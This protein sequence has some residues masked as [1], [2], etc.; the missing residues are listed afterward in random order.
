MPSQC[1]VLVVDDHPINRMLASTILKQAGLSS[2]EACSGQEALDA[3]LSLQPLVIL[4]DVVMPEMDG[5]EACRQL[6]AQEGTRA[7]PVIFV[8][9]HA[10]AQAEA[11]CFECGGADFVTKPFNAAVLRARIRTQIAVSA[12]RRS[13]EGMFRDVI[14]FAPA[15]FLMADAS[16]HLVKTNALAL[17]QFDVTR[18][19]MLD[20][21][22]DRWIPEIYQRMPRGVLPH[23]A[24]HFE[25]D[26]RR[27][28][29][30]L[31]AADITYGFLKSAQQ[32]LGLFIIRD[33]A[34]HRRML[35]ELQDSRARVRA[36]GAQNES[37]RENERKRIAREVHDELGQVMTALRMDISMLEMLYVPQ[38]PEMQ[39]KLHSMRGLV[40]RAISGVRQIASNLRPPALDMGL[41]A[42]M[43]WQVSEFKKHSAAEVELNIGKL[44]A[45]LPE[46]Q[47]MTLY[48]IVQ[49]ALNNIAK[50]AQADRVEITL[51]ADA[52]RLHLQVRDNGVG[53][54]ST[55]PPGRKSF[56]LL[57]MQERAMSLGGDLHVH[58]Q[59]GQGTQ[60]E[61]HWPIEPLGETPE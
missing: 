3:A 41:A 48:R 33:I 32:P 54:V 31:F 35:A 9:A 5:Y 47:A 59:P 25:M 61:A 56:G 29:G 46:Q 52:Q 18:A 13:L 2:A 37:A 10:D 36:L 49:E 28:D 30:S 60:I 53:F 15:V 4:M 20:S 50:Y 21:H 40:D 57:G 23:S 8:T 51:E 7:I 42:A 6:K 22:L 27:A 44:P 16:G 55:L 39:E 14:E 17:Q 11:Q 24:L 12:N 45:Q 58:S 38:V 34:A 19:A 1:D 26:C 43:Q